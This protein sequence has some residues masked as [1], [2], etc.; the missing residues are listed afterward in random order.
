MGGIKTRDGEEILR[1]EMRGWACK[2]GQGLL[3][4]WLFTEVCY[5]PVSYTHLDVYKRQG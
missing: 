5:R 4:R 2:A 3:R 1:V